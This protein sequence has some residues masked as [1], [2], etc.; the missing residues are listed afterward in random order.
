MQKLP[1]IALVILCGCIA[2]GVEVENPLAETTTVPTSGAITT[3]TI[4]DGPVSSSDCV[5]VGGDLREQTFGGD[6]CMNH[7]TNLGPTTDDKTM[8]CCI[9]HLCTE[10]GGYCSYFREQCNPG[11]MKKPAFT[12]D[13]DM[14]SR[15]H[16]C[17]HR[18]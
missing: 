12:T 16:M 3:T 11:Y 8:V 5:L 17:C 10:L 18:V 4:P 14:K 15:S 13:C 2:Q 9:P 1:I 6:P 7:K